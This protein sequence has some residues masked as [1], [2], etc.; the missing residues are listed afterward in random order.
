MAIR[1]T[2]TD[3]G[4]A[5]LINQDNT[6]TGAR[7]VTEIGL[8]RG[9]YEVGDTAR[10]GLLDPIKWV[11]TIAG[12]AVADDVIHV[13]LQDETADIYSVGEIGLFLDNGVLLAYHSQP[14]G[15]VVEKAEPATL[16]LAADIT[17]QNLDVTSLEFGDAAFLNPPASETVKGV[18]ELADETEALNG[19]DLAR[20]MTPKRVNQLLKR[21][22]VQ[23]GSG[24]TGGGDLTKTRTLS[25]DGTVVRTSRQVKAGSGLAGGGNLSQHRTIRV[26]DGGIKPKHIEPWSLGNSQLTGGAVQLRALNTEVYANRST[27]EA[28]NDNS[29]L[30]TSLRVRQA[31]EQHGLG[32]SG[33]KVDDYRDGPYANSFLAGS[34]TSYTGPMSGYYPAISLYRSSERRAVIQAT[35]ENLSFMGMMGGNWGDVRTVWDD[36]NMGAGSGMNADQVDGLHADQFMRSDTTT[37]MHRPGNGTIRLTSSGGRTYIQSGLGTG[38]VNGGYSKASISIGGWHGGSAPNISLRGKTVDVTGNLDVE[39]RIKAKTMTLDGS[40]D[41]GDGLTVSG[42]TPNIYFHQ[43]DNGPSGHVGYNGNFFIMIDADGD[44]DFETPY[45]LELEMDGSKRLRAHG[46]TVW[47]TRNMGHGNGLDA[48]KL[49]GVHASGFVRDG[50]TVMFGGNNNFRF[51]TSDGKAFLQSGDGS[52]QGGW[53]NLVV[54]PY[55]SSEAYLEVTSTGLAIHG[56]EAYHTGNLSPVE[57]SRRVDTGNGLTGGGA[58]WLDRT[59]SI[60]KNG[61]G[62]Y[63]LRSSNSE[64]N[65]VGDLVAQLGSDKVGS[66][67][68]LRSSNGNAANQGD[69]WS[70]SNLRLSDSAGNTSGSSVPGS[71]ECMGRMSS[72]AATLW[73]RV[74]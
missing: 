14:D 54:A 49:D 11:D 8:G 46:D 47:T 63:E 39:Q 7:K 29:Q 23:S 42:N 4:R 48:D 61:V 15:W 60:A 34:G 3:A 1:F 56:Y 9:Q 69:R 13:T 20:A 12:Q 37:Y 67:A 71:W 26:P 33:Y 36:Y 57:E 40:N 55:T 18:I 70:G 68:F 58:L 6:G 24:L 41:W 66:L 10:E 44:G 38:S 21:G 51:T 64:V 17:V 62:S 22:G 50:S 35:G 74:A 65:W 31:Y 16:L 28:G 73:L 27:A 72:N 32:T 43:T 25:V 59:I 45:A 19:E 52:G 30:M 5:A 2:V 53:S